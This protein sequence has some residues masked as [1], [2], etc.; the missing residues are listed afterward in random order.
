MRASRPG[1]A[2][3]RSISRLGAGACTIASQQE[4]S[5]LGR[6]WLITRQLA[7][8]NFSC[9]ATS[10]PNLCKPPPQAGHASLGGARRLFGGGHLARRLCLVGL[11][12]F[13]LQLQLLNQVVQLFRRSKLSR[14]QH[15]DIK[16]KNGAPQEALKVY[17]HYHN[18]C[19]VIIG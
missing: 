7:G 12:V 9:S 15:I 1:P 4:Q 2:I 5:S 16:G 11:Q 13:Q 19:G 8:T 14:H 18:A 17:P 10:S 6:T 3:P